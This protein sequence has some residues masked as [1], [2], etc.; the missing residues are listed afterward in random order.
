MWTKNHWLL[1]SSL[2]KTKTNLN[3]STRSLYK[4]R[5][6]L[7]G[8]SWWSTFAYIRSIQNQIDS[9]HCCLDYSSKILLRKSVTI[10][11]RPSFR[12][13]F[14]SQPSSC[15]ALVISGFLIWGS[16][17][18]LGLNSIV[19]IGSIVSFTT[20]KKAGYSFTTNHFRLKKKYLKTLLYR[21]LQVPTWWT[22]LGFPDWKGQYV[23]SPSEPSIQQPKRH[24]WKYHDKL[25][26]D[27]RNQKVC[28][29]IDLH[30]SNKDKQA[31]DMIKKHLIFVCKGEK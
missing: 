21:P 22:L 7:D 25:R 19:D 8:S 12:D 26:L 18:V 17:A 11:G 20:W 16:S 23:H 3:D 9:S 1:L 2:T 10:K 31:G 27:K 15:L 28:V 13:T 4:H 14:G 5:I 29:A 30:S 24:G 6:V